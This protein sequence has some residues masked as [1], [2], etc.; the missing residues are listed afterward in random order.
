MNQNL[1]NLRKDILSEAASRGLVPFHVSS[2]TSEGKDL[3]YWDVEEHPAFA[4]F[5]D[6]AIAAGVKLLNVF[7]RVFEA[8]HIEDSMEDLEDLPFDRE[9]QKQI[10]KRMEELRIYDGMLGAIELSFH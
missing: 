10:E 7:E 4:E 1:D 3:V 6:A 2:R 8:S 5:L 9:E